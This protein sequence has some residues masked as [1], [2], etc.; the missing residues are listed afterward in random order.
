MAKIDRT[1]EEKTVKIGPWRVKL[2]T[3]C[4][5]MLILVLSLSSFAWLNDYLANPQTQQNGETGQVQ[6]AVRISFNE[7]DVVDKVIYVNKGTNA[8]FAFKNISNITTQDTSSGK[9]A[10]IVSSGNYT[11]QNNG[12]HIWQFYANGGINLRGLDLYTVNDRD[13]LELKYMPSF[14]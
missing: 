8:L 5:V 3:I 2:G 14:E 10:Y 6:A 4:V 12:T 7:N 13:T 1:N 9:L 11:M